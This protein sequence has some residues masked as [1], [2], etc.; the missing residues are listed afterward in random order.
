MAGG[1]GGRGDREAR[2]VGPGWAPLSVPRLHGILF[3]PTHGSLLLAF[4]EIWID[5]CSAR[6]LPFRCLF[7]FASLLLLLW[8]PSFFTHA[9]RETDLL[10]YYCGGCHP[11]IQNPKMCRGR[12]RASTRFFFSLSFL[13]RGASST[14]S[15][16]MW[17]QAYN[18]TLGVMVGYH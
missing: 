16:K 9:Q 18:S 13:T 1:G 4:P 14:S 17:L 2:F 5:M 11:T 10:A 3:P 6:L 15:K 7:R 8:F 12:D